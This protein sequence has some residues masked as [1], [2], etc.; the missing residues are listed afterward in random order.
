M[1]KNPVGDDNE[2]ETVTLRNQDT[3]SVSLVG[4]TLRD[5]SGG[6]WAL[7]GALAPGASRTFRRSGQT[8]SLNNAGDQ[9]VLVDSTNTVVQTVTY[10]RVDEGELVTPAVP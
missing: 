9:I 2:F 8:M 1:R 7:T 10:E 5:R 4:W 6:T 3:H